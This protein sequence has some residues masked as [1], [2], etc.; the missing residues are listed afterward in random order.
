MRFHDLPT[1]PADWPTLWQ[2]LYEERAALME[3]GANYPRDAAERNAE[4][5]IRWQRNQ[6]E[7][8]RA[9]LRVWEGLAQPAYAVRARS[10][11]TR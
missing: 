11:Q 2:E 10:S 4:A 6:H 7:R 5:D 3:F 8:N 1:Y 9:P